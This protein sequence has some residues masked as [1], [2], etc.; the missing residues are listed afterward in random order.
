LSDKLAIVIPT[1]KIEYLKECLNSIAVQTNQNF[2]VYIGNDNSPQ[3]VDSIVENYFQSINIRYVNFGTNL[4]KISLVKHWQRCIRMIEDEEWIWLFSD[5]DTMDSGCVASFYKAIEEH[6]GNNVYRFNLQVINE[7]GEIERSTTYP[8]KEMVED[9]IMH[10]FA[11]RYDSA[12][13]N[14]IFKRKAYEQSGL[15]EFPLAWCSDDASIINFSGDKP[16]VVISGSKVQWRQSAYNISAVFDNANQ[17]LKVQS[18]LAYITWLYMLKRFPVLGI[19]E[20]KIMILRWILGSI[21]NE[22]SGFLP[23]EIKN[24]ESKAGKIIGKS[25]KLYKIRRSLSYQKNR[26]FSKLNLHLPF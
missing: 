1:Y 11:L 17:K 20:N 12:I 15:K 6:P 19:K 14:Y 13:S 2:K 25:I 23:H 8:A 7:H 22:Y 24:L 18:R 26:I 4:G 16:I 3:D 5:D 9:F 10:R 21:H